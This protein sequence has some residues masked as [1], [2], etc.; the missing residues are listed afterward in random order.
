MATNEAYVQVAQDGSGKKVRNL[1][2]QGVVQPDGTQADVYVQCTAIVDG[3]GAPFSMTETNG[4]LLRVLREITA[5]RHMYGR[6]TGM[7]MIA[8]DGAAG[9]N[10]VSG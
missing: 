5:L 8:L 10:D 6:A 9:D 7:E 1:I 4:I 3:D 2:L